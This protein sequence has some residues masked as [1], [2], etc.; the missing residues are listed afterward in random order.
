MNRSLEISSHQKK[1]RIHRKALR[2][3]VEHFLED[4]AGLESWDL[5]IAFL[6]PV[7]MARWNESHL[8][9]EGAAD[10]LTYDYS[11]GS[12]EDPSRPAPEDCRSIQGELLICPQ[13]AWNV[14]PKFQKTWTNELVRYV[15]HGVLHLQGFDDI[16]PADRKVMKSR[17]NRF[18][19]ILEQS[20]SL[21]EVGG[22][23]AI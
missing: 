22:M 16:D 15:V 8:N 3:V 19:K 14:A 1:F 11:G 17:E 5:S 12:A 20:F 18:M 23:T 13:V 6:G 2:P 7:Q 9:H 21:D 10:I 4:I